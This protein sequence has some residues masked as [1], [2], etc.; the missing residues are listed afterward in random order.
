MLPNN[1]INIPYSSFLNQTTGR[2]NQEWLLWLMNPSFITL[3]LGAALA[4]KSG[5]TGLSTIPTNGQLLIGDGTG[6]AL[7][8]LGTGAGISVTNGVGTISI[9]NT[10]VLS[11]I[12]GAGISVSSPTGNVTITNTGVLSWSAGTT[13][14]TPNT[15]TTGNVVLS[16]VLNVTN[17]G[18]GRATG[19]T[20][21]SLV[22]TG[23]TA[24]GAQQTLANAA[25]TE[26]LVGG[27]AA[28]LPVWTTATGTGAPVR[29]GSPTITGH[30]TIEGV[31]STGATGTGKFVF[32]T[33][34]ALV[35]PALGTP[36]SG[37]FST[38]TFT[39]PTFN[40]NTS[41]T[42]AKLATSPNTYAL[43][44]V[45]VVGGTSAPVGAFLPTGTAIST[46]EWL[47][48]IINSTSYWIPIWVK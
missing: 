15:P 3:N 45:N 33:S 19:T 21:Y 14:L 39:W 24:T 7:N 28:A 34:P 41:G 32:D 38:G 29:A 35:T 10:G 48:V 44:G 26:I 36:S 11:N 40:Q 8:T 9:A 20:A 13:G 2:P 16:G 12:A 46:N 23:I 5:G 17:G 30:P 47:E 18:T 1:N 43:T 37:N 25:T 31:T 6:Y 22:A 4:V 42:A 27:G